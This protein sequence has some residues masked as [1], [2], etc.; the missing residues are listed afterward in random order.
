[1]KNM[2][3][4]INDKNIQEAAGLAQPNEYPVGL[5]IH[6][7]HSSLEKL[8]VKDLPKMGETL[9]LSAHAKVH[10]VG[11]NESMHGKNRHVSLQITHMELGSK[12]TSTEEKASILFRK[13]EHISK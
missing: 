7:D 3:R 13:T 5:Q 4:D 9:N 10:A 12:A 1:M 6:L 8:G 2:K 11:H